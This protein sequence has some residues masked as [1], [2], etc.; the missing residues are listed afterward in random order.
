MSPPGSALSSLWQ[1]QVL[2]DFPA[3]IQEKEFV[4]PSDSLLS[5]QERRNLTDLQE[6]SQWLGGIGVPRAVLK[7]LM[8]SPTMPDSLYLLCLA[9]WT[10]CQVVVS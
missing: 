1:R 5:H 4:V 9:S 8:S 10:Q 6:T 7:S 2:Q 3:A